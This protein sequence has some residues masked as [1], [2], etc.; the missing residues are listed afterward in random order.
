M[1]VGI[2]IRFKNKVVKN[3]KQNKQYNVMIKPTKQKISTTY[4]QYHRVN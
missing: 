2:R 1:P 4:F 3:Y